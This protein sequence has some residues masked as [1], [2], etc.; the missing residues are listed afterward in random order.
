MVRVL[1]LPCR[2]CS[3]M[4]HFIAVG[5]TNFIV[6]DFGATFFSHGAAAALLLFGFSFVE[7]GTVK[8]ILLMGLR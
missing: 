4:F 6:G 1:R 5:C 7:K 2:P 3:S 8:K